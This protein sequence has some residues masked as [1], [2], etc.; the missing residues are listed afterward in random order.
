[1]RD[2]AWDRVLDAVFLGIAVFWLTKVDRLFYLIF[3]GKK[4]NIQ[5]ISQS[6]DEKGLNQAGLAQS[7]GVSRTIVSAW[8]KG[9]KFPRPDK[10]LKLGLELGLPFQDLVKISVTAFEPIVAFR[11]KG[12]RKTTDSHVENAKEIGQLL[13]VLAPYLPFEG[14]FQPPF[15]KEPKLDYSYIQKAAQRIRSE[16]KVKNGEPIAFEQ[17]IAKL[18][19]FE[20]VLIPV[21]H[22]RRE[23]HENAL[24]IFLPTSKTT[25]IFL[26]LDSNLHDFKFWM[27]HELGHVLS[28]SL[29]GDS[30]EDFADLYAQALLFP[31]MQ[32]KRAYMSLKRLRSS[33]SMIREIISL[34]DSFKIS[35]ITVYKAI[36]E[37]AADSGLVELNLEP[38]I[39]AATTNFNKKYPNV[40]E[41]LF[42][43][44]LCSA[45]DYIK[46]T[47]ELFGS[48]FFE[49]LRVYLSEN[50]KSGG[51]IQSI[52]DCS[53]LDAKEIHAE[54]IQ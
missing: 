3:M 1:M 23:H 46:K 8:F 50:E 21:F 29:T 54:L 16:I 26:N 28:P 27:A 53:I 37:Y 44:K 17:I 32:A 5:K 19:T 15:L 36:N 13:D 4:L 20:V 11:K 38:D 43:G 51:F 22:G 10:L 40:S 2:A 33:R 48:P 30:A 12:R 39:Y 7:L 9:R 47:K 52:L 35:L 42:E 14:L 31:E 49:A 6:M 41:I 18:N 45:S 34:A 24:H 25:W